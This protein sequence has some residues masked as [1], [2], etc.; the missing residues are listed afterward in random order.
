MA[1]SL[2]TQQTTEGQ[3]ASKTASLQL[4]I[5]QVANAVNDPHPI[6]IAGANYTLLPDDIFR[7]GLLTIAGATV[8]GLIVTWPQ[9]ERIMYV[10]SA[11]A[12]TNNFSLTRGTTS[13]TLEPGK[14][15]LVFSDGTAD[16]LLMW[17]VSAAGGGA[18]GAVYEIGMY[19]GTPAANSMIAQHLA[20]QA[21][22][23]PIGLTTSKGYCFAAPSSPVA[24]DIRKNNV[25]IGSMNFAAAATTATFTFAAAVS[26]AVGDRL[27]LV[28][29]ASLFGMTGLSATLL[30]TK[31]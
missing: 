24:F 7:H 30:G 21:Y 2:E 1:N 22:N 20:A 12:N 29:P 23:L 4:A 3:V 17:A 25:S 27:Q 5:D 6:D 18:G 26:F 14:A 19:L 28:S 11:V 31:A 9:K 8:V 15:Y 10:M 16:G 13:F